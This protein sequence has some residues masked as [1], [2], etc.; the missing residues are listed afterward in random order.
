MKDKRYIYKGSK[1][2]N[3]EI[4]PVNY[5]SDLFQLELDLESYV[6]YEIRK[7]NGINPIKINKSSK[8][9]LNEI[10]DFFENNKKTFYFLFH[11]N[12]ELIGSILYLGN[13]IQSLSIS[14]KYQR[15]GYGEKL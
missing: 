11:E 10:K 5:K 14:K 4:S 8:K 2:P 9:D 1:F 15:Q 6:F 3:I 7:L 13:Y 12:G